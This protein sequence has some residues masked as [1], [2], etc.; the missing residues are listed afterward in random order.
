M[1]SKWRMCVS[2]V[3][4]HAVCES[5]TDFVCVSSHAV[6]DANAKFCHFKGSQQTNTLIWALNKQF[7][8]VRLDLQFPRA[9]N[10]EWTDLVRFP[11]IPVA[12]YVVPEF[13]SSSR[14]LVFSAYKPNKFAGPEKQTVFGDYNFNT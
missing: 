1:R 10:G 12:G 8:T 4:G 2:Y 7:D 5:S 3:G 9:T 14:L 6:Y 13:P 11:L